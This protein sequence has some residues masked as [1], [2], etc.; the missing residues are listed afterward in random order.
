MHN[1]SLGA[2]SKNGILLFAC[3]GKICLQS[4]TLDSLMLAQYHFLQGHLLYKFTK[5]GLGK[6][7]KLF[8]YF[9][10]LDTF[11]VW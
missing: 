10:A 11:D 4:I 3:R 6:E 5:R 8:S 2:L 7:I 9:M 1:V